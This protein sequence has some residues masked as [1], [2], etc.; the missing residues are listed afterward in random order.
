M[1]PEI[2]LHGIF[3]FNFLHLVK[4]KKNTINEFEWV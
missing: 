1:L 4:E 2:I 3:L